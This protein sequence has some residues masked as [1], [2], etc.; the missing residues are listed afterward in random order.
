VVARTAPAAKLVTALHPVAV[1]HPVTAGGT[2]RD[3]GDGA[4]PGEDG[5]AGPGIA[6]DTIGPFRD[7]AG[8]A[9]DGTCS[10]GTPPRA[11]ALPAA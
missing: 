1:P 10:G 9:R 11:G 8:T 6:R 5:A 3:H 7:T 4:G 2:G